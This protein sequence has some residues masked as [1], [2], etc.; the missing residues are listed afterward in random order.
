MDS[1]NVMPYLEKVL[2]IDDN[3]MTNFIN[4]NVAE[5]FNLANETHF[6]EKPQEALNWLSGFNSSTELPD[7]IL[8]DIN[9]PGFDGHEFIEKLKEN[10]LYDRDYTS[11]VFLTSSKEML[12]IIKADE[13]EVEYYY[14]KPLSE[15]VLRDILRDTKDIEIG[16]A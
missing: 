2:F 1:I 14:W 9:M 8:V 4:K 16:E 5:E 3:H 6:Y 10:E 12:D 7:L 11:V 13:A 15:K